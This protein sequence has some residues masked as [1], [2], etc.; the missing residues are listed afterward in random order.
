MSISAVLVTKTITEI[1]KYTIT[2]T[3]IPRKAVHCL[4]LVKS[5]GE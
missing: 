4:E 2:Y 1:Q 3:E 5:V